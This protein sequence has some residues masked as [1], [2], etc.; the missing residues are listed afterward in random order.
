MARVEWVGLT[1]AMKIAALTATP[2]YALHAKG[3]VHTRTGRN[4]R[5]EWRVADLE[6]VRDERAAAGPAPAAATG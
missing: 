2:L 5:L 6:R 1:A 3:L 4:G